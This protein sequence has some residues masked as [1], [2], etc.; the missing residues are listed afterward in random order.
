LLPN[1]VQSID[2][3]E[4][5]TRRTHFIGS[6]VT[7]QVVAVPQGVNKFLLID[8]QQRYTT[9][10][11]LLIAIRDLAI[12][13]NDVNLADDIMENYLINKRKVGNDFY[14]LQ[15]TQIDRNSYH[16]LIKNEKVEEVNKII[17]A[18]IYFSE[19][20]TSNRID[21]NKLREV[22]VGYLSMVGI[23]LEMDKGDDPYLVFE[24]LNA[25]GLALTQS[26]LIRNYFFMSIH[27]D[28][29]DE[30]YEKY[31][32]PMQS[33]L[34]NKLQDCVRHYLIKDEGFVKSSD[35]YFRLKDIISR[36]KADEKLKDLAKFANYYYKLLNPE[37]E[38]NKKISKAITRL[39]QLQV[40]TSYPFFL[41]CYNEF[42]EGKLSEDDFLDIFLTLENF[43]VRRIICNIP[44]NQL[45]KVF[46][47]LYKNAKKYESLSEGVRKVLQEKDYPK[48]AEFKRNLMEIKLY[49]VGERL[50]RTKFILE[51]IEESFNHKEQT[52]LSD[53]TIEHIMPQTLTEWWKNHLGEHYEYVHE[54]W[55]DNIGNLTL[56]KYNSE[57]SNKSF[58][59]KIEVFKNSKIGLNNY[60]VDFDID[61]WTNNEVKQRA[62][63]LVEKSLIIWNYFGDKNSITP[64]IFNDNYTYETMNNGEYLE[65][66]NLELLESLRF[67]LYQLDI[68]IKEEI[69]KQTIEYKLFRSIVS[70]VPLRSGLK[71]YINLSY[72]E[73]ED[74]EKLCRDLSNI[75][76]WGVGDVEFK[77]STIS[78]LDYAMYLIK[79]SYLKIKKV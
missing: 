17:K 64:P 66:K 15:P 2:E 46:P 48:D 32:L 42:N 72:S 56:T 37:N 30:I 20:I 76:H 79:Q 1:P 9:L 61:N 49:G 10:S 59:Q 39:N 58:E 45:N 52:N 38:S 55:L 13:K 28:K 6:L 14:K 54:M 75:G 74:K 8:G 40:T 3:S 60:F 33:K 41:N 27:T 70:V 50:T 35:I 29:H 71:L 7:M 11:I 22:I 67:K 51:T 57:L 44:S 21:L 65:G 5:E 31:W 53:C 69:Q 4:I 19:K 78:Q 18:H 34:D 43:M 25:T 16:A 73:L 36:A 23:I 47:E 12:S 24:S 68:D 77:L 62:E 26:D 63:W